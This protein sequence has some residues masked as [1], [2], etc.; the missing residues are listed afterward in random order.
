VRRIIGHSLGGAVAIR[1]AYTGL[2]IVAYDPAFR[3]GTVVADNVSVVRNF[4]DPVSV[5]SVGSAE[6]DKVM[7]SNPHAMNA[8]SSLHKRDIKLMNNSYHSGRN[9]SFDRSSGTLI[10]IGTHN[11]TDVLTDIGFAVT[12]DVLGTRGKLPIA[13]DGSDWVF[14]RG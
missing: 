12:G 7:S 3:P 5:F 10:V 1:Y 4:L 13:R 2:P 9:V 8:L 14:K 11:A 6:N